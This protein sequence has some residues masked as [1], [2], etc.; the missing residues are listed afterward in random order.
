[1]SQTYAADSVILVPDKS[2]ISAS[3]IGLDYMYLI[4]IA[5]ARRFWESE[6][7]AEDHDPA[8]TSGLSSPMIS[9]SADLE[10][11]G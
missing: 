11:A 9:R 4:K 8:D 5:C 6:F 7:V 3:I 1:M 2:Y 10:I